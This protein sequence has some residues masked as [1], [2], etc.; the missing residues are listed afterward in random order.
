MLSQYL[1]AESSGYISTR[2]CGLLT[3]HCI[4]IRSVVVLY[5][6]SEMS[7]PFVDQ[8]KY[9]MHVFLPYVHPFKDVLNRVTRLRYHRH[10]W[11]IYYSRCRGCRIAAF[12]LRSTFQAL[13]QGTSLMLRLDWTYCRESV[14]GVPQ[15]LMPMERWFEY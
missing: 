11:Q 12:I 9:F 3:L 7:Y 10:D 14:I 6:T 1:F 5:I 15:L 13:F 8:Q 4:G 2:A